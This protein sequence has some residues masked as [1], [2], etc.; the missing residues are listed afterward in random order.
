V[1]LSLAHEN[2]QLRVCATDLAPEA[3]AL[4]NEN[5]AALGLAQRFSA[6]T[7]DLFAPLT[8]AQRFAVIVANPPYI[9]TAGLDGLASEVADFEPRLALDGGADGLEVARRII[10]LARD[11]L[12]PGGVVLMELDAR[13]VS[14]ARRF[15]VELGCWATAE[16]R[17][18]LTGRERFL[19]LRAGRDTGR[20]S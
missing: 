15:A 19:L 9:P 3:V 7:G 16:V 6:V 5:A 20:D 13:N 2:P 1:G 14:T 11:R 18:D 17:R 12:R 10:T 4:A 8:A